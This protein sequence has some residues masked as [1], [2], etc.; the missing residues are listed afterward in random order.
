MIKD[1]WLKVNL[2]GKTIPT[3]DNEEIKTITDFIAYMARVSSPAN[4]EENPD[5]ERLIKYLIRNKHWSP[6]EM[7]HLAVEIEAPRDISRQILR[8]ASARFQEFSQRYAEVQDFC[9][10]EL[11]RQD[12]KNRQNSIDDFSDEDKMLFEDDCKDI[13]EYANAKYQYWLS[14]GAAKE[15]A[16]VFLPEGLT[17]SR[18]YMSASI[19]TWLHYLEIREG[20]GT[21]KEHILVANAIREELIKHEPV[22]FS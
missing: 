12:T 14:Q 9:V 17:M 2:V 15:T 11:R 10:R 13:I 20:N 7:C 22:L 1:N 19:R 6:F 16:R 4:Q 5:P 21:Q 8:H 18:L 3:I